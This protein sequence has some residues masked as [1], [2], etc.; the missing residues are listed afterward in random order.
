VETGPLTARVL[1][2]VFQVTDIFSEVD[3]EVRRERLRRLWE[4]YGFLIVGAAVLLVAAVAAWR[5]Y[6]YWQSQKAA[7]A[8][9]AFEAAVQLA[10]QGNAE[11]AKAAFGKIAAE[12]T[13]AYRALAKIREAAVVAQ[14]DRKAAVALYDSVAAQSDINPV[15]RD[16]AT[17][18]AGFLLADE[19]SL[20]DLTQRLEPLTGTDRAFRHSA[21]LLLA[22]AAWRTQDMAAVRRWSELVSADPETPQSVRG[23][24]EMLAVMTADAKS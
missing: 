17:I 13:P 20:A 12:G 14:T 9:T 4:R 11:E 8:G 5:G 7:E 6:E 24:V 3:E 19:A 1:G 16:V 23:Q 10:E 2:R 18:R 15:M 21:R 22:L